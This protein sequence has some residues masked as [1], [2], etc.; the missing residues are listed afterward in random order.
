MAR[1]LIVD[2]EALMRDMA[3]ES[4]RRRGHE[5]ILARNAT[6]GLEKFDETFALVLSDYKMPGATGLDFLKRLR[7]RDAAVPL[8]V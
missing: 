2:D 3:A 5:V 6:E 4:L 7:E 8:C 1:I